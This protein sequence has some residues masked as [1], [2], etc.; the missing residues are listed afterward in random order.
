MFQ[1]EFI[2][3]IFNENVYRNT[4]YPHYE[5]MKSMNNREFLRGS[6][7]EY[8]SIHSFLILLMS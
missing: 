1:I 8:P 2:N 4:F 3:F 5:L 7:N 6:M